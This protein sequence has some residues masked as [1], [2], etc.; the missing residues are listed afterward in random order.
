MKAALLSRRGL[1][2]VTGALA[3]VLKTTAPA[4]TITFVDLHPSG[5]SRS[6]AAAVDSAGQAGYATFAGNDHAA[7]WL[8]T[9]NSFVDLHP[10]GA[11]N[12]AVRGGGGQ[13]QAGYAF[14]TNLAGGTHAAV[15]YGSSSSYT[16]LD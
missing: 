8:G 10:S 4:G 5:A 14:Y 13:S 1:L 9:S 11:R 16:D 2:A 7:L 6:H 12:S 3:L 15:W